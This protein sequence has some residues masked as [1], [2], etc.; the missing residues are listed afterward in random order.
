MGAVFS[1]NTNVLVAQAEMKNFNYKDSLSKDENVV[2][3]FEFMVKDP[4]KADAEDEKSYT[5]ESAA[6]FYKAIAF[7]T[8]SDKN[9]GKNEGKEEFFKEVGNIMGTDV[10]GR[11]DDGNI[12]F[13]ADEEEMAE[14]LFKN[15]TYQKPVLD[16]FSKIEGIDY[17]VNNVKT[18]LGDKEGEWKNMQRKSYAK[19]PEPKPS[20]VSKMW[21]ALKEGFSKAVNF[22]ASF[23]PKT[24]PKG[25]DTNKGDKADKADIITQGSPSGSKEFNKGN[26]VELAKGGKSETE[27][28]SMN[29]DKPNSAHSP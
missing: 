12:S 26:A 25:T 28:K 7:S 21:S 13:I 17:K 14:L 24:H 23:M 10:F 6:K 22:F 29:D 1:K 20:F 3:F 19:E 16:F 11:D 5:P 9:T 4:N 18:Y 15:K 2:L 27:T 8:H